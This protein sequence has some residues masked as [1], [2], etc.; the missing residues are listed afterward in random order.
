MHMIS[1]RQ[2]AYLIAA[3]IAI[4]ATSLICGFSR[5][6]QRLVRPTIGPVVD[7]VYALGIVKTDRWYNVRFGMNA[8]IQ[9]LYVSE[10]Q[11]IAAGSP[12]LMTDSGIIFRAPF[13]GTITQLSFRESEMA[14][15]GQAVITLADTKT[16]Y[17]RVS[18]DQKSVVMVRKGQKAELSFE[19][20]RDSRAEGI[21]ES[22]YPSS[23]EFVVRIGVRNFPEGV[24]PEMNCDTAIIIRKN[25]RALMVPQ[26]AIAKNEVI[27]ERGGKRMPVKV[28]ARPVDREFSEIVEGDIKAD[29]LVVVRSKK[30]S[31][32]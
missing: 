18:L 6:S 11:E 23:N 4:A 19:N 20:L 22:V 1:Q 26:N 15:A 10:G 31:S 12:L 28:Q 5:N 27:I 17:V 25:E 13:S 29:D 14:P 9:R 24:L 30:N 21:V 3:A 2:K 32:Q 16:M 8:V 7:A